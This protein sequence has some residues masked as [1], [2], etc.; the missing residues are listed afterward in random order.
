MSGASTPVK[1][2]CLL[3]LVLGGFLVVTGLLRLGDGGGMTGP[4]ARLAVGL[5]IVAAAGGM[6]A[7]AVRGRSTTAAPSDP[8]AGPHAETRECPACGATNPPSRHHCH[9]CDQAL[10]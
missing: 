5:L 9:A 10:R 7:V 3:G 8:Q 6:L 2:A 1:A 4:G